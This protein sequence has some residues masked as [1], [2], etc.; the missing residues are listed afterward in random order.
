MTAKRIA[1]HEA[2][3]LLGM[4]SVK[5]RNVPALVCPQCKEVVLDGAVLDALHEQ[6]LLDVL[7]SGHVSGEE[8]RFIRK[9]LGLS[10]ASFAKRLGVHRVSVARWETSEVP[11]DGPTS[12]AI[13]ALAAIPVLA[14]PSKS[15][16]KARLK[17]SFERPLTAVARGSYTLRA[18][19]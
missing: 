19:G 6:L 2:G 17:A 4:R 12:V 16:E 8:V 15:A 1:S 7:S 14:R 11:L 3:A 5:V 13:R 10:Q 9:A 18:T